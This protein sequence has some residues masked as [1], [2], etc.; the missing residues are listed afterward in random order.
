MMHFSWK[1]KNNSE[2]VLDRQIRGIIA[3]SVILAFIPF[4]I[5]LLLSRMDSKG[6]VL[7]RVNFQNIAVEIVAENGTSGIYFV[8]QGT[9]AA[10][11]FSFLELKAISAGGIRLQNGMKIRFVPEGDEQ[12]IVVERMTAASL[13]ALGLPLDINTVRADDLKL[14]PGV[15]EVLAENIVAWR[16]R[17][18]RFEKLDQLLEIKGIKEKKLSKLRPYLY[19]DERLKQTYDLL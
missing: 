9:S 12:G 6:P 1:R 13:L 10:L 16:E 14:I 4:I 8:E 19:V 2:I 18:G 3:V 17:I 11:L 5:Y 7:S 15:G